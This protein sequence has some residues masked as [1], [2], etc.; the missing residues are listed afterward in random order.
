MVEIYD[1]SQ[2][3]ISKLGNISSRAFVNTG[4]D[5]VI[6]GFILGNGT[7]DDPI[8]IRGLGP[9]LSPLS[10]LLADPKLEL[11]NSSGV[12]VLS[13]NN[14]QDDPVQAAI[15]TAAGLA[16]ANPLESAIAAPLA[17][18]A[19]TALLSGVNNGTGLGLVEVY[20]NPAIGPT[21]TP[22]PGG[23][24]TPTP[25]PAGGRS[26]SATTAKA[27]HPRPRPEVTAWHNRSKRPWVGS[28]CKSASV[29]LWG[30]APW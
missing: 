8:I 6:A 1:L 11:R 30:R 5:I 19:Y 14:W 26:W 3:A 27:S 2:A 25:T 15:V 20:D 29:R 10:P 17:P 28:G 21:P 18:G 16:P 12:L 24:P 9:S 22:P 7:S 13:N 4:N 23:T